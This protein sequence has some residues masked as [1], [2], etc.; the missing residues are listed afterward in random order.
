MNAEEQILDVIQVGYGPVSQVLAL[1]L[2]RLGH[3]VAV[4]ERWKERYPLPRAVCID[5]EIYRFLCSLG[6]SDDLPQ[7]SHGG[8]VYRIMNAQWQELMA[9]D[10]TQESVSGGPETH[11]LHQPTLE[12]SLDAHVRQQN[13]VQLHLGWEVVAVLQNAEYAEVELR[14]AAEGTTHRLKARYVIGVDGANSMVRRAIGSGQ[15]DLGFEADWLVVDV[16]PH[17]GV[18][19]DI[20][21]AAQ[22]CDPARPTT[23]VPGGVK[24]GRFYRRWEFM[25]L[26]GESREALEQEVAVWQ[27]LERWV[28]RDQA[29]LIRHKVYTF[30]SLLADQW[31]D[32]RILLAGDAAHLMPPF[33]GQGMCSGLRDVANL[34]WKLDMVLREQA[35]DSLLDTYQPERK[36][37]VQRIT[38][39]SM[40]IGKVVCIPDPVA[41]NERDQA[42]FEGKV[43]ALPPF[44]HLGGGIVRASGDGAKDALAGHL[45]P[46][47]DVRIC[48]EQRRL[49]ELGGGGFVLVSLDPGVRERLGASRLGLMDRLGIRCVMLSGDEASTGATYDFSGRLTRFM[50]ERGINAIL[51]RPDFYLY[52]SSPAAD[53]TPVLLDDLAR[54][55]AQHG[56]C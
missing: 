12:A 54:D 37:H 32:R 42:F 22:F 15:D 14:D 3:R 49:D 13:S 18:E 45:G 1:A 16:L 55:L 10:W 52:G 48:G 53:Q 51:A 8:P 26:P 28:R 46:H 34:T 56:V 21:A 4:I 30:R 5:H 19:L 20:P 7:I 23:M 50:T 38:E 31:R 36:E 2:G 25:C 47:A 17:P 11:F 33:M 35:D 29:E 6:L 24:D 27:L 39:M 43:G 40:F 41:A 9:I 44:P